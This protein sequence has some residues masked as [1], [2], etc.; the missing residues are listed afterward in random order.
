MNIIYQFRTRFDK[1]YTKENCEL[2][3]KSWAR[4][5]WI[6]LESASDRINEEIWNKWLKN[7]SLKEKI[8]IINNFDKAWISFHNYSIIWFPSETESESILTYNFIIKNIQFFNHYTA[9]P[10]IFWLMK[11]SYIYNNKEKYWIQIDNK[12]ENLL[13]LNFDFSYLDW[14]KRDINLY[15]KMVKNI[16]YEQFLPWLKWNKDFDSSNFFPKDFWDYIDRSSFFYKM[17]LI[18]KNNP[19][20][21][22]KNINNKIIKEDLDNKLKSKFNISLWINIY[23]EDEKIIKI[24]DWINFLWFSL[25]LEYKNFFLNFN[26]E[27]SLEN[28][29]EINWI[30]KDKEFIDFLISNRIITLNSSL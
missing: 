18:Y 3:Y 19:Y 23:F 25:D 1:L 27:K 10:N 12:K 5:C 30:K 15:N 13:N 17:K 11:W 8:K 2:L 4:Y 22:Y 9:T 14:K 7:I 26:E 6:W 16:H 21:E 28:N 29:L 24:Y 20:I